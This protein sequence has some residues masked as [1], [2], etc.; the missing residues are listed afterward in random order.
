LASATDAHVA[1]PGLGLGLGRSFQPS[2]VSRNQFGRFGW[3]WSDSWQTSITVD[4]DGSVDVHGPGGSLR[5]FQP[6]L[7]GGYFAQPG[8][9]GTLAALPGGGYTLT[10]LNGQ[11]TA[12][13]A[14]G[15]LNYIQ[16]TNGNRITAGYTNGL[17]TS[18]THSSGQALTLAYNAAGLVSRVTDS[19]GR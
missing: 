12:Y 8:D 15:T 13:N 19:A 4:S 1:A 6:D 11:V 9:H 2:L 14:D 17:L 5:R 3:G 7:R 16:D 10:E 18:L